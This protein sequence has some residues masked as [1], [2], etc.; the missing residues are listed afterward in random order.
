MRYFDFLEEAESARLGQV[1]FPGFGVELDAVVLGEASLFVGTGA[2]DLEILVGEDRHDGLAHGELDGGGGGVGLAL[3]LLGDDSGFLDHAAIFAGAAVADGGLI[4]VQFD[5][6][7]VDAVAGEGGEDV[8]DG[9]DA[10]VA[11]GEGGGAVGFGDVF[12]AGLD[13]GFAF[14]V[15]AAK[16]DAGIGGG[17]QE[18]HGDLVAAVQADSGE[19]DWLIECLLLYHAAIKLIPASVGKSS[20]G[21]SVWGEPRVIQE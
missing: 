16:A 1:A 17:G 12:D 9:M 21:C 10:G 3:F 15:D 8:L 14:E 7:V 19:T 11:L 13:L 6:G 2:G 18:G 4:G 5:D 20:F